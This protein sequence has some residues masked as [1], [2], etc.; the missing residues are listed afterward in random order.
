MIGLGSDKKGYSY[1][2]AGCNKGQKMFFF[3]KV[4]IEKEEVTAC[5]DVKV[6]IELKL[7]F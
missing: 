7:Q 6:W 2:G 4:E 3:A 1:W 5:I